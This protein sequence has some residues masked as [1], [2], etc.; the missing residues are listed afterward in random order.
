MHRSHHRP[1]EEKERGEGRVEW[2][3]MTGLL[4]ALLTKAGNLVFDPRPRGCL[5]I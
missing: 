5:G 2:G 3:G 4:A 1:P